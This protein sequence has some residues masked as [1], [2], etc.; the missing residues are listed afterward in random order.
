MVPFSKPRF[1]IN[2]NLHN[3]NHVETF[4]LLNYKMLENNIDYVFIL[5]FAYNYKHLQY[6]HKYTYLKTAMKM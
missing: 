3:S 1:K 4:A 6:T 2:Q 5:T